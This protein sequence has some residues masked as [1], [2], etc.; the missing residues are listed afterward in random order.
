[1]HV[2]SSA[3]QTDWGCP[4]LP[5]LNDGNLLH[6]WSPSNLHSSKESI[7]NHTPL[8]ATVPPLF[9]SGASFS[10]SSRFPVF[11]NG[12]TIVLTGASIS[13]GLH[14]TPWQKNLKPENIFLLI[15]E[16]AP[17]PPP[18]LPPAAQWTCATPRSDL[19]VERHLQAHAMVR[20]VLYAFTIFLR[21]NYFLTVFG[22]KELCFRYS[23]LLWV[24]WFFRSSW[25]DK[26]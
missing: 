5:W 14:L 4:P 11:R 9:W 20:D 26:P 7:R 2:L 21:E 23:Y 8:L 10:A 13:S 15:F 3:E 17:P 25:W 6:Y 18:P 22:L 16:R 12:A 1:M 24:F 19:T